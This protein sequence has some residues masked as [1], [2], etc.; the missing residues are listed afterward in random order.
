MAISKD[1]E[2]AIQRA[3]N[4]VDGGEIENNL[5]ILSRVG[6]TRLAPRENQQERY[7]VDRL[8]LGFEDK[9]ARQ[10]VVKPLMECFGMETTD[11]AAGLVGRFKGTD[12]TLP[13]VLVW[14]HTD[15]VPNGD[16]YDGSL[17]V[18]GALEMIRAIK[19]AGIQPRRDIYIAALTGEE[20]ARFGFALFGS[21]AMMV[22]LEQK[23]LDSRIGAGPSIREVLRNEPEALTQL[24]KPIFGPNGNILP[25]PLAILELHV[26]QDR[27]LWDSGTDIGVVEAI[28]APTRHKILIG[29]SVLSPDKRHFPY[30]KY[31]E[32]IVSGKADHSGA[33]PMGDEYRAD[34]LV[35]SAQ[36]LLGLMERF[37]DVLSIGNLTIEGSAL[38]KIPGIT[39]TLLRVTGESSESLENILRNMSNFVSNRDSY[40]FMQRYKKF[41]PSPFALNEITNPA[42]TAFFDAEQ[43]LPRQKAALSLVR[44]VSGVASRYGEQKVVGTIGT[45]NIRPDGKIELGLDLRGIDKESRDRAYNEILEN[46][47]HWQR[48]VWMDFGEKLSGSGDPVRMD[49]DLVAL[50]KQTIDKY[51]IG[52]CD[53]YNSGAGHD[54]QWGPRVGTPSVMIFAQSKEG[55]AHNPDAF[56][57][58][59]NME[60]AVKALTAVTLTLAL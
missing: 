12:P 57:S 17:G 50:T 24:T 19:M 36:I 30:S 4:F 29:D 26:E 6:G 40:S 60:K 27:K 32:L 13:P 45:F 54:T 15:S 39:K 22:G 7:A 20:S 42:D 59:E 18:I 5:I 44:I 10:I 53:I 48:R 51:G 23:D 2:P 31:L 37:P 55:I 38:N 58:V 46:S 9:Q 1:L 16:P 3:I 47:R 43:S 52:S 49:K 41:G 28:A 35:H 11:F 14:S 25:R 33:T 21:K 56:T 34:G 8:A